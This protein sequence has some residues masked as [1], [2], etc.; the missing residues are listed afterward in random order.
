M[1]RTE[2]IAPLDKAFWSL[3]KVLKAM[4]KRFAPK[5]SISPPAPAHDLEWKVNLLILELLVEAFEIKPFHMNALV[6]LLVLFKVELTLD[7][8]LDRA[9]H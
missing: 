7:A 8:G 3:C 4:E 2:Q 1:D 6:L 9:S 5:D